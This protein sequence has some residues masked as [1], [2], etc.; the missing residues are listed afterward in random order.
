[1]YI[2]PWHVHI[3]YLLRLAPQTISRSLRTHIH[4]LLW[5]GT[6]LV[7]A[8]TKSI[9]DS[10]AKDIDFLAA[11]KTHYESWNSI[12]YEPRR[13]VGNITS[14][15]THVRHIF[16]NLRLYCSFVVHRSYAISINPVEFAGNAWIKNAL[17]ASQK[18][19][20]WSRQNI[21][22]ILHRGTTK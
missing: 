5:G 3:G 19:K 7:E 11:T 17:K 13:H 6:Q 1:M 4:D 15:L 9:R 10:L 21:S 20:N 8:Q 16:I 2:E 12:R 14:K 22:E 18:K